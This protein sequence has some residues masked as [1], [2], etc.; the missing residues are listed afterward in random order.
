MEKDF[1][2]YGINEVMGVPDPDRTEQLIN[3]LIKRIKMETE[4]YILANTPA[5]GFWLIKPEVNNTFFLSDDL[6]ILPWL[7]ENTMFK[8]EYNMKSDNTV[9]KASF[10]PILGEGD[11]YVY[12]D[13]SRI[14]RYALIELTFSFGRGSLKNKDF[15]Q[16]SWNNLKA[17]LRH[18]LEHAYEE[19]MRHTNFPV[20]YEGSE[21][22]KSETDSMFM[23]GYSE[24]T[25]KMFSISSMINNPE[26]S[27]VIDKEENDHQK[28]ILQY[29]L[30]FL[31][32]LY[33]INRLEVKANVAGFYQRIINEYDTTEKI[34]T[35]INTYSEYQKYKTYSNFIE[36]FSDKDLFDK[37]RQIINFMY[38]SGVTGIRKLQ[39]AIKSNSDRFF[40][41]ADKLYKTLKNKAEQ[42]SE[43]VDVRLHDIVESNYYRKKMERKGFDFDNMDEHERVIMESVASHYLITE[44]DEYLAYVGFIFK[45]ANC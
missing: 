1:D 26:D 24:L 18:E 13:G 2:Y 31:N 6:H 23:V 36:N 5:S 37:Y 32:A 34:S 45:F 44:A 42:K 3:A 30:D 29:E 38:G 7:D 22:E 17:V 21:D 4:T 15:M 33:L 8:Y 41:K 25:K 40:K 19:L 35:D 20:S 27:S 39:L 10:S 16:E 28:K 43:N 11:V 12:K 14:I 9:T